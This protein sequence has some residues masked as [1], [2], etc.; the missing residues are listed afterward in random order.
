MEVTTKLRDEQEIINVN[1]KVAW[2]LLVLDIT[3]IRYENNIPEGGQQLSLVMVPGSIS[4][5]KI[6]TCIYPK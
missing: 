1:G 6:N 5:N 4:I 2:K 3:S